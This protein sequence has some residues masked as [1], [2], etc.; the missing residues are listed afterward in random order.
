MSFVRIPAGT[1]LTGSREGRPLEALREDPLP[2]YLLGRYEVTV[3]AYRALIPDFETE[4]PA[5]RPVTGITIGEARAFCAE[6]SR[7][8]GRRARLPTETEWE[9]AAR[10]G[11]KGAP[12]PWGRGPV[13]QYIRTGLTEPERV[14]SQSAN[15][16]GLHDMAG[17]VAEWCEPDRLLPT[18][19]YPL[20]ARG[21]SWAEK[22][23]TP[24]KV[25][26][27]A[28]FRSDY[29]GADVGFRVLVETA[30]AKDTPA[31]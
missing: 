30:P 27:R 25:W 23:P 17:S 4:I 6:L 19:A 16:Y 3:G 20:T 28:F 10:G 13:D 7:R 22:S 31:P 26:H 8:T 12:Y 29:R 21:G 14:G 15:P 11:I 1:A 2:G 24:L 9:Y 5:D 18:A